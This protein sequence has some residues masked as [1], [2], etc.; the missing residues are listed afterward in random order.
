M[1][2]PHMKIGNRSIGPRYPCFVIAEA[3]VNHNGRLDWARQLIDAAADAGADA[4]KFQ[5]F[6]ADRLVTLDAP[7]ADYQQR[8]T[9]T[10][11]SQYEILRELELSEEAHRELFDHAGRRGLCFLSSPFDEPCADFLSHLGVVAFKIPSGEITN[12]DYLAHIARKG[13]PMIVS[14]GMANLGEVEAAVQTMTAVGNDQFVLLHCVSN[15]PADPADVNLKAMNCLA[16][17]FGA[18][19]G[20]SDH[21]DGDSVALAAVALGACVIEKHL[22]LDRTSPGPDHAASVEPDRLK[23]LIEAIRQVEA[24][25][26]DGRKCARPSEINTSAVARKSIVAA[27]DLAAGTVLGEGT[28]VLR[29]PGTGIPPRLRPQLLG[30]TLGCDVKA[31]TLLTWEMLTCARWAS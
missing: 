15:Y 20:Y 13:Q 10:Q 26:G 12:L 8:A 11:Q 7:Q 16:A 19:V 27:R 17:A 5:T 9:G 23:V 3:G 4:V 22:T 30:R 6:K 1:T 24:A 29:R 18:P 2:A 25:L 31:G 28:L 14:T 21:C